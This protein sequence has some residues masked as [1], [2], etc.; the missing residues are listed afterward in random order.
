MAAVLRLPRPRDKCLAGTLQ[1]SPAEQAHSRRNACGRAAGGYGEG[2]AARLLE[3]RSEGWEVPVHGW[4]VDHLVF[5]VNVRLWFLSEESPLT[6]LIEV[7]LECP[8]S[9]SLGGEELQLDPEGPPERLS[10]VLRLLR[11]TIDEAFVDKDGT[12]R[13]AFREGGH[14]RCEP[15]LQWEAWELNDPDGERVVCL[16]TGG[17]SVIRRAPSQGGGS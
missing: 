5:D 7:V 11:R 12:L 2:V 4:R 15:H 8:F 3:E 10:P 14:V 9:L 16:P 1:P 6:G 13:L 17:E